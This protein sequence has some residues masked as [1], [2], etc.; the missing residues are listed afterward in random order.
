M[1]GE[2]LYRAIGPI[3]VQLLLGGSLWVT[4]PAPPPAPPQPFGAE[5]SFSR[6]FLSPPW[7]RL[8]PVLNPH[9]PPRGAPTWGWGVGA[10]KG[11]GRWGGV[12]MV[13]GVE[14]GEKGG[15]AVEKG[16]DGINTSQEE[17]KR[18]KKKKDER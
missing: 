12:R 6:V 11:G 16:G 18:K 8:T 3:W 13:R 5:S 4:P 15:D 14:E 1:R 7:S 9:P 17:R 2:L 10:K